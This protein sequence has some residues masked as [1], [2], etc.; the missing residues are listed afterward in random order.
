MIVAGEG[1]DQRP[2]RGTKLIIVIR[3]KLMYKHI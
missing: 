3:R 1:M 2:Y